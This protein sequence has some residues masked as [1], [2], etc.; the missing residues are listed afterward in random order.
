MNSDDRAQRNRADAVREIIADF[1]SRQLR[2][3][4]V[5]ERQYLDANPHLAEELAEAF[6]R[7]RQ[8]DAANQ[9]TQVGNPI[10]GSPPPKFAD[11]GETRTRIVRESESGVQIPGYKVIRELSRGG[12]G[13]V[14]QGLQ[15]S[16]NRKVAIKVLRHGPLS[17]E[18]EEARF[19]REAQVLAALRHP[20]IVCVFDCGRSPEGSFYLVM[21]YVS[22]QPL[23]RWLND[24]FQ[25]HPDGPPPT[26]PAEMLRLFMKIADAVNAA[27]L[28]GI[29]HRDL[30]PSNIHID[31]Q[32][33]PHILD[34]GLAHIASESIT[35]SPQGQPMTMTGQFLGSL[36][37]ASPEQAEGAPSKIDCRTDVYSLGVVLY[38]MLTG[39]FPY[40]VVGN[41]R[42]V[43]DNIMRAEP[44]PPSQVIDS[45]VAKK[46]HRHKR[47]RRSDQV[48]TVIDAIVLKS[49]SKNRADRYQNAGE[50]A[51][52]IGNYLSGRPTLAGGEP[53]AETSW[54]RLMVVAAGLVI[55]AGLGAL[56]MQQ[57]NAVRIDGGRRVAEQPDGGS[58]DGPRGAGQETESSQSGISDKDG[59]ATSPATDEAPSTADPPKNDGKLAN[60]SPGDPTADHDPT[61]AGAADPDA[62]TMSTQ[63]KS[64]GVDQP[65]K[66]N[67]DATAATNP[68]PKP[69][70]PSTW[71]LS[72]DAGAVATNDPLT[73][74]SLAWSADGHTLAFAGRRGGEPGLGVV[75]LSGMADTRW[76]KTRSEPRQLRF[77]RGSRALAWITSTRDAVLWN[78]K[79]G[80]QMLET[81]YS[82]SAR[83]AS[84]AFSPE[85]TTLATA[86]SDGLV[87]LWSAAS[88]GMRTSASVAPQISAIDW[89]GER[90]V[91]AAVVAERQIEL[92]DG[93]VASLGKIPLE[94]AD[95]S[96][97]A[98]CPRESMLAIGLAGVAEM[99]LIDWQS[100][101]VDAAI[102]LPA[103]AVAIRWSPSGDRVAVA[104][105]SAESGAQRKVVVIDRK[106]GGALWELAVS[107]SLDGPAESPF[108]WSPS[109]ASL[110]VATSDGEALFCH[111][112]DGRQIASLRHVG[113]SPAILSVAGVFRAGRSA[114]AA[115]MYQFVDDHGVET[116]LS[117]ADFA[118]QFAFKNDPASVQL[119][120]A[121]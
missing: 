82:S 68:P 79:S 64:S 31:Q 19:V 55:A 77:A 30:K 116:Q 58:A 14:F 36:P 16:T 26:N 9:P 110:A 105:Q 24:Y 111:A 1:H 43:L 69:K 44:S 50:L 12:Q 113:A 37:W 102:K 117:A 76:T 40:E 54:G 71:R 73:V 13:V 107:S 25:R 121:P 57:L 4:A 3:E 90:G 72:L 51:R 95:A 62:T 80:P 112:A 48:N 100:K 59:D 96:A 17:S 21:E 18:Q 75:D 103:P 15:E 101:A 97:I 8:T 83:A 42:D 22:G 45:I 47:R 23:D 11:L 87:R 32:G 35:G 67:S 34:F 106:S 2:G 93:N 98:I 56:A 41:M 88:G 86:S 119:D 28:R 84:V 94:S 74:A 78:M 81:S 39:Q 66:S 108:A 60:D 104:C 92:F 115:I 109:G 20:N 63:P 118:N 52:D 53:P 46:L 5:T 27:H 29:V 70:P 85:G 114:Q 89:A 65:T 6:L 61:G 33:E 99:R 38:Q 7:H 10:L 49:L 91:I 120:A